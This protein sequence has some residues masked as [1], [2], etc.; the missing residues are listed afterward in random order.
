MT[1]KS[2]LNRW[3][4]WYENNSNLAPYGDTS[5]YQV[6]VDF[7]KDLAV[8][9]WGCGLGWYKTV[10]QGPY[11]GVDGTPSPHADIV[12]DL[13]EYTSKTPAVWMRHVLEHNPDWRD[14]L[15]NALVSAQEKIVIIVFTPNGDNEQ[16]DYVKALEVPDIALPH[17][18]IAEKI[19]KAG[20]DLVNQYT[21]PT[22]SF[23][24]EETVF[25][26]SK[27]AH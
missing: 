10:H 21:I 3:A 23:Y 27:I 4:F 15:D 8:E 13:R 22:G 2:Y 12:A 24:R 26:A 14:I 18:E 9:D 11:T 25:L 20:F 5:T 16:I 1:N 7:L 19:K 17:A 6:G